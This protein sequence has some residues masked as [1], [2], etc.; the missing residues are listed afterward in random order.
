MSFAFVP[1]RRADFPLLSQWLS[2]PHVMRWWND[3]PSR[4]AIEEDYGGCVDG[5]EPAEVFLAHWEGEAVGLIQRYRF[6]AYPEYVAEMAHIVAVPVD[7]TGIDYVIG[8]PAAVGRGV[9]AAM[10]ADFVSRTW[11]DDPLTV[12]V[13]VPVQAGNL[14]SW[15]A[16]ERAGFVRIAQ[17]DLRPDN[18]MDSPHHYIYRRER[19]STVADE[20]GVRAQQ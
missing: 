10:I 18:P 1:I 4:S 13:I 12:A 8:P 11:L 17:G 2:T 7:A 5:T 16:L 6:G 19:M 15:R 20:L 9:G 14:A 3:D